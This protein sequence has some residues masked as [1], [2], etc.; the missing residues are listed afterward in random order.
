[1][2]SSSKV[3]PALWFPGLRWLR[4]PLTRSEEE[5]RAATSSERVAEATEQGVPFGQGAKATWWRGPKMGDPQKHPSYRFGWQFFWFGWRILLDK[6]LCVFRYCITLAAETAV[7][8]IVSFTNC[9]GVPARAG[10]HD[11]KRFKQQQAHDMKRFKQQQAQPA[12]VL[13]SRPRM[14]IISPVRVHL[15]N[16]WDSAGKCWTYSSVVL[17]DV[18][19][20]LANPRSAWT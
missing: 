6:I 2:R 17:I 13:L 4:S 8:L 9:I 1:M 5:P 18:G 3:E 11:M 19:P 20:Q 7:L 12:L 16:I 10:R 14:F 15:S